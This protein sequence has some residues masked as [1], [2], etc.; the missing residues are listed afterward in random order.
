MDVLN[1]RTVTQPRVR[2]GNKKSDFLKAL[3]NNDQ[4]LNSPRGNGKVGKGLTVYKTMES[5]G[6]T[7]LIFNDM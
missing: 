3:K 1:T 2:S 7:P 6:L 4:D 5:I